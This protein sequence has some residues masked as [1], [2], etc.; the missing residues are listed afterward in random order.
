MNENVQ[1]RPGAVAAAIGHVAWG[2]VFLHL[3]IN[4]GTLDILPNWACYAFALSALPGLAKVER[5]AKLLRPL[6]LILLWVTVIIWALKAIGTDLNSYL[7]TAIITVLE[8]YFHFQLLTNIAD[9]A[10][11]FDTDKARSLKRLR[12]FRAVYM[13]LIALPWPFARLGSD[14][15]TFIGLVFVVF[16]IVLIIWTL[17][18]LFGLKKDPSLAQLDMPDQEAE[19]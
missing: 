4:L 8:L 16:A 9:I 10:A 6:G 12:N 15:Q 13:T 7:V 5:S 3:D 17:T 2:Y 1:A 11:R 18:Q 19:T 14:V